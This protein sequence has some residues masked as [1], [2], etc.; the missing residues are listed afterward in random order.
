M[1]VFMNNFAPSTIGDERHAIDTTHRA[2]RHHGEAGPDDCTR[3]MRF[4]NRG[5]WETAYPD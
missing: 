5:G 3:D 2:S 4:L 1:T